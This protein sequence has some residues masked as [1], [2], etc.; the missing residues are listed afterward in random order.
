[1]NARRLGLIAMSICALLLPQWGW[2]AVSNDE[3]H[4]LSASQ[5]KWQPYDQAS[6]RR[7]RELKRPVFVLVYLDTCHWCKKYETESLEAARIVKRLNRDYLPVGVNSADQPDLATQLGANVVPTTLLLTPDGRRMAKF[8][9]FVGPRDLADI[10]DANLFRWKR[11]ELVGD[12][13]G[14]EQ[15]CCPLEAA[16]GR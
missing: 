16:P 12:E 4:Y 2:S 7:A 1:M 9:G 8:H 13:F 11:G 15:T 10:L 6:L 5:I 3:W 14:D